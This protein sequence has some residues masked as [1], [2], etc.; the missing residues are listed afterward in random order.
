MQKPEDI[1]KMLGLGLQIDDTW[2]EKALLLF[3]EEN[4]RG[5]I[6]SLLL[7]T[8]SLRLTPRIWKQLYSQT[9]AGEAKTD[10]GGLINGLLR[11]QE[12]SKLHDIKK[13]IISCMPKSG[14]SFLQ[15]TLCRALGYPHFSCV[16]SRTTSPS[17][18]GVN[19]GEQALDELVLIKNC[20]R[21]PVG[22]GFVSQIHLKGDADTCMLLQAHN[23]KLLC[24][25]RNVYD[26]IISLDNMLTTIPSPQ[27]NWTS[28]WNQSAFKVPLNYLDLAFEER[29]ECIAPSYGTWCIDYFVGWKRLEKFGQEIAWIDYSR[30]LS[31]SGGNKVGMAERIS[32]FLGLT[33]LQEGK[34]VDLCRSEDSV[35]AENARLNKAID[36]RGS[37]L[38]SHLRSQLERFASRYREEI[39]DEEFERYFT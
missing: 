38:P 34:F 9:P 39:S 32:E 18:F 20:L 1:E 10:L 11:T 15:Q 19:N 27:A 36:G 23:A 30:D 25:M 14:S 26:G 2:L 6:A 4:V 24:T 5:K 33:D 37:E 17:Q 35:P 29:M 28:W 13:I 31:R 21:T 7:E 12:F 16:Y 22:S 8:N 3:G